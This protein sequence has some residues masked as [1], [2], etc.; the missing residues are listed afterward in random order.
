MAV[1]PHGYAVTVTGGRV[2]SRP[3]TRLLVVAQAKGAT[4]VEVVV[5]PR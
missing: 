4:A 2:V 5:R 3:G 1:F